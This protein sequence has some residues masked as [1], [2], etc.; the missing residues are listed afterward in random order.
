MITHG[1]AGKPPRST[2][3]LCIAMLAVL[4][5]VAFAVTLSSAAD[6]QTH[7]PGV[8]VDATDVQPTPVPVTALTDQRARERIRAALRDSQ[9]ANPL[10]IE[11]STSVASEASGGSVKVTVLV[12]V[13]LANVAVRP[14]LAVH[15]GALSVWAG[16]RSTTQEITVLPRAALPVRVA[17]EQ[18]LTTLG[19]RASQTFE[20]Q[21]AVGEYTVAVLVRDE[22]SGAEGAV[23]AALVVGPAG[24]SKGGSQ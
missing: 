1:P 13:P 5:I 19:Q 10:G 8:G 20:L 15:E 14:A 4:A 23:L 3:E 2:L 11:V 21:L 9:A 17:N 6:A 22:L 24:S 12:T 18:L 7:G 16:I